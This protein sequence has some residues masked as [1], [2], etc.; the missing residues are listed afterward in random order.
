MEE[1]ETPLPAVA[2]PAVATPAAG[3]PLPAQPFL[4]AEIKVSQSA[5]HREF[6][7]C[8]PEG[9]VV[10]L[11]DTEIRPLDLGSW[12]SDD[13]E[14]PEQSDGPDGDDDEAPEQSDG[15]DGDGD[16]DGDGNAPSSSHA[17][18]WVWVLAAHK[19]MGKS[20]AIRAAVRRCCPAPTVLNVTFRRSLA[21]G[22]AA[23]FPD[24]VVYLDLPDAETF[25]ARR[26][27]VLTILVNSLARVRVSPSARY[28]VLILDEWVSILEMLG[29]GLIG[30]DQR[31]E[32]VRVLLEAM[33]LARVVVVGDALLDGGSL[34][35]LA[36]CLSASPLPSRV[37]LLHYVHANHAD[38]IYL[39]YPSEAAWTAALLAAVRAGRRVVVPNMTKAQALRLYGL[40]VHREGLPE[41]RVLL[42]VAGGEHDLVHHMAHLH[43]LWRAV[44]VVIYSPVIT[45]GCSFEGRGHFDECF[46][47][48]F[49]GTASARSA[50]QMTFR[51]RDL[52]ARRIHV[53]VSRGQRGWGDSASCSRLADRMLA[54]EGLVVVSE[55]AVPAPS[56]PLG[57]SVL[58]LEEM[59]L[60][61]HDAVMRAAAL[62]WIEANFCFS[63]A[64][65]RLVTQSGVMVERAPGFE[66][67][68]LLS[69]PDQTRLRRALTQQ[70]AGKVAA[71]RASGG[72]QGC[73]DWQA[74][75]LDS[76]L[77]WG[78]E[79]CPSPCGLGPAGSA[80]FQE[81][82]G[83]AGIA[84]LVEEEELDSDDELDSSEEAEDEELDY[85]PVSRSS[86][87][88]AVLTD[89]THPLSEQHDRV[90]QE[91]DPAEWHAGYVDSLA[92]FLGGGRGGQG[93]GSAEQ[94]SGSESATSFPALRL[95]AEVRAQSTQLAGSSSLMVARWAALLGGGHS[96]PRFLPLGMDLPMMQ[97]LAEVELSDGS[98]SGS[99]SASP[100]PSRRVVYVHGLMR[101]ER[102]DVMDALAVRAVF[103]WAVG[104]VIRGDACVKEKL[105]LELAICNADA[106]MQ[107]RRW[108][109]VRAA[110][111]FAA[112]DPET[113]R[114]QPL[115]SHY[116][117][118]SSFDPVRHVAARWTRQEDP[119]QHIHSIRP[120]DPTLPPLHG[121][122]WAHPLSMLQALCTGASHALM[123]TSPGAEPVAVRCRPMEVEAVSG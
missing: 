71:Y 46:L 87:W 4:D 112:F 103:G 78:G 106:S 64:F 75:D 73:R 109:L 31:L 83:L 35:T 28:D 98:P 23:D 37:T 54:R 58:G 19:G 88:R 90:A 43:Q 119:P 14:A 59:L 11:Q 114:P 95:S 45:A 56:G 96:P 91:F 62:R 47:Y 33:H 41:A 8:F 6:L 57:P 118:A 117:G 30:G 24:G 81:P 92:R 120:L 20:K 101:L 108:C 69:A 84:G 72:V 82:A 34:R 38:H 77:Q 52:V 44:D 94:G 25:D 9:E 102:D 3:C 74:S 68:S 13:D 51:V 32:I 89:M 104:A 12:E 107:Y 29:G 27:P 17:S 105:R 110:D 86:R 22:A 123:F 21:R 15:P 40:L 121:G 48:A 2:T 63:L 116:E 16:G 76:V 39:A 97:P 18:R 26:H 100:T 85:E 67:A 111:V 113:R 55:A 42:Y 60:P 93:G 122:S 70:A 53:W 36:C 1:A 49:Q 115:P 10:T 99:S 66:A 7:A 80:S 61:V 79:D 65:W 50:L 5:L